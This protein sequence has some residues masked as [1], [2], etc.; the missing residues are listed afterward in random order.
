M[1]S[2]NTIRDRK[3]HR[4]DGKNSDHDDGLEETVVVAVESGVCKL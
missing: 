1:K 2:L 4:S 3:D